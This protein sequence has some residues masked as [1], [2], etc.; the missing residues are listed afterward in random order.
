MLPN[1]V[2]VKLVLHDVVPQAGVRT[3]RLDNLGQFMVAAL[4]RMTIHVSP[5]ELD[6]AEQP[7]ALACKPEGYAQELR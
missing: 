6:F 1:V 4:L 2:A 7:L 5:K 3:L